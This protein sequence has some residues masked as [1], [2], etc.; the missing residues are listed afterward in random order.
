MFQCDNKDCIEEAWRCDREPDCLDSSDEKDC[1][2]KQ[3]K[4]S[5]SAGLTCSFSPYAH[6]DLYYRRL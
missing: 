1:G 2:G 6:M 4:A 5:V 3:P